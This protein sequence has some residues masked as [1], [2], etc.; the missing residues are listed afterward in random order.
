M[1]MIVKMIK[2]AV[3]VNDYKNRIIMMTLIIKNSKDE[4]NDNINNNDDKKE[5]DARDDIDNQIIKKNKRDTKESNRKTNS[6]VFREASR[7]QSIKKES[8]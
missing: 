1:V 6:N 7:F 5:N 8:Q 2:L 4:T 3:S